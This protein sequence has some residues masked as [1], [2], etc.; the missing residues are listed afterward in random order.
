MG[1]LDASHHTNGSSGIPT[2]TAPLEDS[3]TRNDVFFN[4]SPVSAMSTVPVIPT[5]SQYGLAMVSSSTDVCIG[6][7]TSSSTVTTKASA[8]EE[9]PS[10]LPQHP[11]ME[12][13]QNQSNTPGGSGEKEQEKDQVHN[14]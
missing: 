4:P 7:C 8:F 13:I 10:S 9:Q 12:I 1:K 6:T 5:S 14:R 11:V 2:S 3:F